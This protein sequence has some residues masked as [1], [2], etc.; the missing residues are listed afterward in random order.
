MDS[1]NSAEFLT[2]GT[3]ATRVGISRGTLR[4]RV[5]SGAVPAFRDPRDKRFVLV[6]AADVDRLRTPRPVAAIIEEA[7]T[8]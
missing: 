1:T 7:A 6:R 2:L 5:R 4:N 3:A 8:G